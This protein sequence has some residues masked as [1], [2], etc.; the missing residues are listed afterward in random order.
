MDRDTSEGQPFCWSRHDLRVRL[1]KP[2]S[3]NT[4]QRINS[5]VLSCTSNGALRRATF[6]AESSM[7]VEEAKGALPTRLKDWRLAPDS[8]TFSYGGEEVELSV[9]NTEQAFSPPAVEETAVPGKKRKR[10]E[11]LLPGEL[12]RAKNVC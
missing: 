6:A 8:Q 11:A 9:W 12:W 10:S 4:P 5:A 1:S 2:R 3:C 7:P